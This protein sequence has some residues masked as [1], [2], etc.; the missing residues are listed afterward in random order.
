MTR[1]VD[2]PHVSSY[3]TRLI[4][5]PPLPLFRGTLAWTLI[6]IL[7]KKNSSESL[8]TDRRERVRT[9]GHFC[10]RFHRFL[11]IEGV[12][13]E[14]SDRKVFRR[15]HVYGFTIGTQFSYFERLVEIVSQ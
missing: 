9:V 2:L 14:L 10:S 13:L 11:S 8:H 3:I 12:C 1:D 15:P 4:Q 6:L 7:T 5:P